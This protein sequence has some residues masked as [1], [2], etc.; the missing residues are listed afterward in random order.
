MSTRNPKI[1]L[2][3]LYLALYDERLPEMRKVLEPFLHDIASRF[4]QAGIDVEAAPICRVEHEIASAVHV[5]EQAEIDLLVVLHLAYSP[6][7]EAAGALAATPLPL[8]LLDTTLDFDF[9]FDVDP[10]RI[11]YNHGIHGVQ[12]LACTLRRRGKPFEIVA[13]HFEHSAVME[14]ASKLARA[15]R[16]ARCFR[17]TRVLRIGPSFHAMGDF[18]VDERTL[19]KRLGIVVEQIAT[20]ELAPDVLAVEDTEIEAELTGHQVQFRC[21]LPADVHRRSVR[22]GLGLRRRLERG[23][24]SAFSMNFA[25][26]DS[27]EGPVDTVP[28]LEA[29]LAMA[30]GIGYAGEGDVLTAALVGALAQ[31]FGRTTFTE[32]FCPDWRGN[33][34]FLSHMGEVN[35]ELAASTPRLFEKPYAFSDAKNPATLTCA[36]APGSAVLVNLAPGPADT[37]TLIAA[38]VEVLGDGTHPGLQ[39]WIRAWVQPRMDLAAFLEDYSRLGGTHHSALVY[40]VD[41]DAIAGLAAFAGL[42]FQLLGG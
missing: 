5:L 32:I 40:G 11:L 16:A 6:S 35:P 21:D 2:L 15:A 18:A 3:P 4:L 27:G 17:T 19:R 9:G 36:L 39:D 25:A 12:D 8:L 1:G 23:G 30:R 41:T 20:N 37:F 29:S 42:P 28:F 33:T 38:P 7:L 24:Y 31:A 14:R 10:V 22:V 26:F 13:G 34:L